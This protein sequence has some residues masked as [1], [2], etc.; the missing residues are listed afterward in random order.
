MAAT[1]P[2]KT[3]SNPN[4]KRRPTTTSPPPIVFSGG[5]WCCSDMDYSRFNHALTAGLLNPMSP[6][7]P[8]AAA[9]PAAAVDKSRSS[10][11]L[12]EMMASEQDAMLHR[13][14][15]ATKPPAAAFQDRQQ[16]RQERVAE[17]LG[18]GSPGGRF[19][20]AASG[21]V[22]LTLTSKDGFSV[23]L[24]LHRQILAAHSRF[25]ASKLKPHPPPPSPYVVEISDC[26]D[27]EIYLETLRLMYCHDLR[28]RL[29]REDVPKI[30]GILKVPT[31]LC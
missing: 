11:T 27:V 5:A 22:K 29:M 6:P 4:P 1:S 25:F 28:R 19:N 21:D 17:I 9:L 16:L 3:H 24:A 8:P 2:H 10:P 13:A 20:D 26:D 7:P 23:S 14:S 18:G 12:F 30:L 31:H 15:P